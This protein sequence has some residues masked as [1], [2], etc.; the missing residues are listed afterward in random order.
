MVPETTES[1]QPDRSPKTQ[2][3]Y[4][5]FVQEGRYGI[6]IFDANTGCILEANPSACKL[7]GFPKNWL[8]TLGICQVIVDSSIFCRDFKAARQSCKVEVGERRFRRYDGGI[9]TAPCTLLSAPCGPGTQDSGNTMALIC[10]AEPDLPQSDQ[11]T[12]LAEFAH[13]IRNPLFSISAMITALEFSPERPPEQ[14]PYFTLLKSELER[15][16]RMTNRLLAYGKASPVERSATDL[17]MLVRTA[18]ELSAAELERKNLQTSISSTGSV[19]LSLNTDRMLEALQYILENAIQHSPENGT[20]CFEIA[21]NEQGAS[22]SVRDQGAGFSEEALK[23]ALEP[24]FSRRKGGTGL[25]LSI[26][27]K[28]LLEHEG[29][30]CISNHPK[31]GGRVVL[32]LP[33]K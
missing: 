6:V 33:V 13:E 23:R 5:L 10:H 31:G 12:L 27:Q 29:E 17:R 32:I 21:R 4:A 20:I 16:N 7:F 3:V 2:D 14:R 11:R 22:I 26:A 19:L 28:I 24:F 15:V 9:F 18:V 30:I 25:G 1:C 8:G